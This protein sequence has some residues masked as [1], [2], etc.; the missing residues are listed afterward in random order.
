MFYFSSITQ[1]YP[2]L[3]LLFSIILMIGLYQIGEII[4]YNKQLNLIFNNISEI[5]YQKILVAINLIMI[6]LLPVVLFF[7]YSKEI[8]YILSISIFLF[9]IIKIIRVNKKILDLKNIEYLG[10]I[11]LEKILFLVIFLGY[12]LITFSPINHADSLDYHIS[13][14][15]YIFKTGNLP[16][17]L[18]NFTNLL[19]GSGEVFMSLGFFFGAEQFGNL[20][21]FSGL[22]SLF[23]LIKKFNNNKYFFLLL[24]CSSP[25][26]I[27]LASSPKPQLFHIASI[28][29]LFVIVFIK[30][31]FFKNSKKYFFYVLLLSNIFIINSINAKFSFILSGSI[32]YIILI[33]ASFK[34]NCVNQMIVANSIFLLLFFI[35]FGYWKS[36]VWGGNF[37]NYII[38]PLPMHLEGVSNF[39][40][41]LQN[42]SRETLIYNIFIPK[43]F[44][45][46]TN[47]MGIGVVIFIYF[48]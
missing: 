31:N 18:E 26:L 3:S 9:G 15:E 2:F 5:N 17:S 22:L 33:V 10:K 36:L 6:L 37:Y 48:F 12:F 45:Q 35:S 32:I 39:Y 42:Y 46:F 7:K 21:Q 11:D 4:L 44:S 29:I 34:R 25:V 38:N 19:I 30:F 8:I 14:S 1:S 40:G 28:A 16:T 43:N 20:I 24:I 27:F 41:Y 13:G 23:G 47:A